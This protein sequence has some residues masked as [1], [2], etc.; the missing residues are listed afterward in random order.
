MSNVPTYKKPSILT[1][2]ANEILEYLGPVQG[3]ASG[4]SEAAGS[5]GNFG[6]SPIVP[7]SEPTQLNRR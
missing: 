3:L 1:V 4:S 6:M 2:D 5:V 7:M